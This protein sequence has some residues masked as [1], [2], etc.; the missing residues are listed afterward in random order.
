LKNIK[1]QGLIKPDW[2]PSGLLKSISKQT[3]S[4]QI[5]D[6]AGF[7]VFVLIQIAPT[8]N[9][10]VHKNYEY[11]IP[12]SI[13]ELDYLFNGRNGI[14]ENTT[15]FDAINRLFPR[16]FAVEYYHDFSIES[17]EKLKQ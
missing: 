3:K 16:P 12:N 14:S 7:F 1:G 5:V 15:N 11:S 10:L 8:I 13:N 9:R 2:F 4:L 17:F 6:L